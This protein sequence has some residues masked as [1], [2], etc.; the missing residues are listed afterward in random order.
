MAFL[1]KTACLW[2]VQY[3]ISITARPMA[4]CNTFTLGFHHVDSQ[5]SFFETLPKNHRFGGKYLFDFN[6]NDTTITGSGSWL[7]TNVCFII[8]FKL[9]EKSPM[10][11]RGLAQIL[12]FPM[13]TPAEITLFVQWW[14]THSSLSLITVNWYSQNHIKRLPIHWYYTHV[15]IAHVWD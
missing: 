8:S 6:S 13:M 3:D 5:T 10:E 11:A 2:L 14:T 4:D 15:V 1:V 12:H 9:E 7:F